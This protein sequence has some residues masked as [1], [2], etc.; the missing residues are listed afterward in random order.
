MSK[1]DYPA[2]SCL[3]SILAALIVLPLDTVFWFLLINWVLS[4]FNVDYALTWDQALAV[5]ITTCV[6]SNTFKTNN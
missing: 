3:A 2:T 5:S 4:V 6:L 1:N